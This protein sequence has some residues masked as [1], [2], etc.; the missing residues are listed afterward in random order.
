MDRNV[1]L[2]DDIIVIIISPGYGSKFEILILKEVVLELPCCVD[3][4][5]Q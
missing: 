4:V 5:D 1:G 2:N 3:M